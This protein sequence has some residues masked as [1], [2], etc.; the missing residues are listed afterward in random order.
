MPYSDKKSERLLAT[1]REPGN[2]PSVRDD[3]FPAVARFTADR[4]L[5]RS[6]RDRGA[7]C[8]R[9]RLPPRALVAGAHARR[10]G[11]SHGDDRGLAPGP[12]GVP[13]RDRDGDG[14]RSLRHA[15]RARAGR[16]ELGGHHV[17]PGRLPAR[18]SLERDPGSAPR[19][20][21][22]AHRR[23]TILADVR[24]KSPARSSSMRSSGRSPRSWPAPRPNRTC[25]PSSSIH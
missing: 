4:R 3:A 18:A 12:H 21:A 23:P 20:R 9:E 8:V 24:G 10:E 19:V 25:W 7:D 17:S 15:P 14:I 11:G 22:P 6:V 2:Y 16:G 1:F 13:A 5:F